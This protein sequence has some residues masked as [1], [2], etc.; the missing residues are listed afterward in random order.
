MDFV[1]RMSGNKELMVPVVDPGA[2]CNGVLYVKVRAA[3]VVLG[4]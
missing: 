3:P 4:I 1:P 2:F